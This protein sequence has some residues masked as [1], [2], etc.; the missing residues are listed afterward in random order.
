MCVRGLVLAIQSHSRL[1]DDTLRKI[2][3]GQQA[4]QMKLESHER[5]IDRT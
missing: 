3:A 2:R 4:A 5:L 1:G